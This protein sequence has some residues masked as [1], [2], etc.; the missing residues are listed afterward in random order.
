MTAPRE[1]GHR[2]KK[3]AEPSQTPRAIAARQS[4]A[5]AQ[6]AKQNSPAVPDVPLEGATSEPIGIVESTPSVVEPDP[7]QVIQGQTYHCT[8]CKAIIVT[9]DPCCPICELELAWPTELKA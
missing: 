5:D 9:S 7:A 2:P 4:R 6:A 8:N 3:G 1:R